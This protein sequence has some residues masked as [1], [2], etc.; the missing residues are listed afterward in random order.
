MGDFGCLS[1]VSF[2]DAFLLQLEKL[3]SVLHLSQLLLGFLLQPLMVVHFHTRWIHYLSVIYSHC[4][5]LGADHARVA[6]WT[7]GLCLVSAFHAVT[8]IVSFLGVYC[9]GSIT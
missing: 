1:I 6:H 5:A 8:W 3:D 9:T 4:L 7:M 2:L